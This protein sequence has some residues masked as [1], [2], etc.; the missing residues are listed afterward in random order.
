M[1]PGGLKAELSLSVEGLGCDDGHQ[2]ICY[3]RKYYLVGSEFH[4]LQTLGRP[5]SALHL[6]ALSVKAG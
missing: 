5:L 3:L 1:E 4:Q 6:S 2:G